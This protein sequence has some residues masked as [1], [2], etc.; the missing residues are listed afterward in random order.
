MRITDER[1]LTIVEMALG[2]LNQELAGLINRH[3]GRAVG[4]NGQ[5]GRFIHARRMSS[6]A[7]D[8]D[9]PCPTLASSATSRA[10]MPT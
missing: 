9:E 5:D 7:G 8:D 1:T 10:S 6:P 3:G 2:E 4:L